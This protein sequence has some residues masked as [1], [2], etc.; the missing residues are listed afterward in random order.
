MRI[1]L[2]KKLP[3]GDRGELEW[4]PRK[5]EP[6]DWARFVALPDD[7]RRELIDGELVETERP[8][9]LHE[10][11]VATLVA[12][13]QQWVWEHGGV[14]YP[15]GYKVHVDKKRGFMPDVQLYHPKN[16]AVR[17]KQAVTSGAPDIAVEVL[18][19]CTSGKDRT[20]KLIGY[21]HIGVGEYWIVD[22]EAESVERLVLN[23]GKYVVEQVAG[24]GDTLAP[25]RFPGLKISVQR[26]FTRGALPGPKA[27]PKR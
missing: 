3:G 11:V 17:G 14:A 20:A 27:T 23:R 26:L 1:S 21:A 19:E 2:R 7:D 24:P 18:S 8:T 16:K 22:P 25:S 5:P 10:V 9:E 15:S 6:A 4:T 13:F 12:L